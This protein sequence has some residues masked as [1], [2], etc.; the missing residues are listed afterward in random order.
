M[1]TGGP[2]QNRRELPVVAPLPQTC[3]QE[4]SVGTR[5]CR[6]RRKTG[7]RR[8][9]AEG[10]YVQPPA[11][12]LLKRSVLCEE[13]SDFLLCPPCPVLCLNL[14]AAM[15]VSD[16]CSA[17]FSA[18]PSPFSFLCSPFRPRCGKNRR[19]TFSAVPVF[20]PLFPPPRSGRHRA[21]IF[22]SLRCRLSSPPPLSYSLST[23]RGK[24]RRSPFFDLLF[25]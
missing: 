8:L 23:L 4:S 15:C 7:F 12:F 19:R 20:S 11:D 25:S 24:R 22:R 13:S 18:R 10:I 14:A 9:F 3:I 17:I 2:T 16:L 1:R 5:S 21:G 6:R